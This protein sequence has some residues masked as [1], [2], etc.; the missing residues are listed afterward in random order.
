MEKTDP[1]FL[2][3]CLSG[4]IGRSL[5]VIVR[6]KCIN[7]KLAVIYLLLSDGW[8]S[9]WAAIG[10][11]N[12]LYKYLKDNSKVRVGTKLALAL[13][14]L[15]PLSNILAFCQKAHNDGRCL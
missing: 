3:E 2:R 15:H 13:W 1:S 7:D 4:A 8:E 11:G 5:N 9:V 10:E 6:D 12:L 14:D